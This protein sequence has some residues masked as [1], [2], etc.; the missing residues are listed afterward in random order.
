MPRSATRGIL[1]RV[2]EMKKKEEEGKT[3]KKEKRS[4]RERGRLFMEK[5]GPKKEERTRSVN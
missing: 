5:R 4:K 2:G 1:V 3:R